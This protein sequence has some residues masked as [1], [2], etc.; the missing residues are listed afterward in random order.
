MPFTFHRLEI[1]DVVMIEAKV[2]PDSRGFFA[3]TY[4]RSAFA[5]NGIAP[6]FVQDNHSYSVR[7]VLRGLHY[8]RFPAAQAKLVVAARGEIFD[9]AVDIR[10]GSPQF[11]RWYGVELSD[12][13]RLM[14]WVPP[15]FA[16]GF[17]AL[18]DVADLTYKCTALYS[19][20]DELC[21]RWDDPAIG[22]RWP[23]ADPVLS[24]RLGAEA[25]RWSRAH[26]SVDA[27]VDR[28]VDLY[29]KLLAAR[30]AG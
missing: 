9:V 25:R 6:S 10:V 13:N 11:G 8:Q 7:G 29:G 19:P 26:L 17:C 15:G 16:H 5:Q 2:F 1:P 22:I 21:V 24:A 4:R 23:A 14:L 18:S 12:E 30:C 3:E 28:H 27:M 20:R